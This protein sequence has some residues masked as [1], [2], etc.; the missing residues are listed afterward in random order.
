MNASMRVV[1]I[2]PA[3]PVAALR[4]ERA[5]LADRLAEL[6][7]MAA[8]VRS[9]EDGERAATAAIDTLGNAELAAMQARLASGSEDLAPRPDMEARAALNQ[10][11]AEAMAQAATMRAAAAGVA[12]EQA[13]VAG[14]MQATNDQ[15]EIDAIDA[16]TCE[17]ESELADVVKLGEEI[18][19]RL[20]R[21]FGAVFFLR[22]VA[23][24]QQASGRADR[25]VAIFT[26][27]ER[28]AGLPKPEFNPT[29]LETRAAAPAWREYFEELIRV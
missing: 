20:A 14:R 28:L 25:A 18:Q 23:D 21:T 6:A 19:Q 2:E 24:R 26:A 3:G 7:T 1:Q 17:F 15:I 12:A 5:A 16:I 9:A 8:K 11:L 22:E 4:A 27:L 13:E 29:T 10:Q